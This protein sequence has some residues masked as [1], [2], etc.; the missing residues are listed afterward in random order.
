MF[1]QSKDL[2][3]AQHHNEVNEGSASWVL[4]HH[5]SKS[6]CP[7]PPA[8]HTSSQIQHPPQDMCRCPVLVQHL[9]P[10]RHSGAAHSVAF[11][12]RLEQLQRKC[13][14]VD[15]VLAGSICLTDCPKVEVI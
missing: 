13:V 12:Y 4:L 15:N 14:R 9:L 2:H 3:H 1:F 7:R 5:C 6:P 11:M 8:G 10:G